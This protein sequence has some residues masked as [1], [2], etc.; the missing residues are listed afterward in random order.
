[1]CF[2]FCVFK[3]GMH[4]LQSAAS[5]SIIIYSHQAKR[6]QEKHQVPPGHLDD[7]EYLHRLQLEGRNASMFHFLEGS[8]LPQAG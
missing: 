3:E 5:Q 8:S 6:K 1:M 7:V 4:A 2:I